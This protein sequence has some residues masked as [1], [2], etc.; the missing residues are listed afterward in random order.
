MDAILVLN[1]GSSSLKFAVFEGRDEL[2]VLL[3]GNVSSLGEHP[4]LR[5][6]G[7]AGRPGIDRSLGDAMN[8]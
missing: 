1:G 7:T 3:R 4:R 5:A 8:F 6:E 2:P